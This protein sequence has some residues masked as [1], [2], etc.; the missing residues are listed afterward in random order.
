MI[1]SGT[2]L[3][4]YEV[5]DPLGAG[6]MGEVYKARDTRLDRNV[7]IKVLPPHLASNPDFKLRFE[8]EAKVVSGLNHPN[9]CTLHDIG[10]DS[11]V[12]YLVM[13]LC[14]GETLADRLTR[15]ALPVDQVLRYGAQIAEALERAHRSGIVHRDLKPGNIMLT[16][17]GAKLLD[18]GLAK[19]SP[20]LLT[21]ADGETVQK[22]LTAEGAIVG[23]FQYMAPEQ[24][25][26]RETD[27]RSDIFSFGAILYEMATGKRA[28]DGKTKAS[29]I[30]S[31]L[32][33]QPEPITKLQP[34]APPALERVI[35]HALE[36]D[37]DERWQTAH[38]LLLELRWI[39]EAGSQ[40]GVAA[41]VVMRRKRREMLAWVLAAIALA[42][43]VAAAAMLSAKMRQPAITHWVTVTPPEGVTARFEASNGGSLTL[44]PDGRLLTFAAS[45]EGGVSLLWLRPIDSPDA[46]PI[47]GTEDAIYPFWSPDSRFIAFF[48]EG[49]LK[50]VDVRGGPPLTLCDVQLN[51]RSGSWNREG[52]ILF[53]PNSLSPIHRV[54][55]AGG[56]PVPVT[57][58]DA[59]NG[60]TTHRWAT[61]LPDGK[62]FLY[63][64]GTHADG[65]RSEKN[66]IYAGSLD[67]TTKKLIVYARSNVV[68]TNGHLLYLRDGVLLAHAFDEKK[69]E[70]KGD[71]QSVASSVQYALAWFHGS[72][73]AVDDGTLV[74][75]AGETDP[76]LTLTWNDRAGKELQPAG[77]PERVFDL[78]LSPDGTRMAAA[79]EDAALGTG[80]LWLYDLEGDVRSRFTFD[81]SNEDG[82]VWSPDGTQLVF[83]Q[84]IVGK[85]RSDLFIKPAGGRGEQKLLH[86]SPDNKRA[87]DWSRDGRFIAFDAYSGG[88]KPDVWIV[89]MTDRKASPFLDSEFEESSLR[90]SPDGRWAVYI[91]DESGRS[92]AYVTPFPERGG[93]WQISNNGAEGVVW[94]A[95]GNEIF[96]LAA[97]GIF[98]VDVTAAGSS[99][100]AEPPRLLFRDTAVVGG[101]VSRD[102]QRFLLARTT[103]KQTG[104]GITLVTNWMNTL[105]R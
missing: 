25:E 68:Y 27:A 10:N 3:G 63:L 43:A 11:G 70:V 21:S 41:P 89:S 55:A 53:S 6:G 81:R 39:A 1:E 24:L 23:T 18:F 99:F 65:P 59:A 2:R 52:V 45:G 102:G 16:K 50:K 88:K 71:P 8:R 33:R 32:D 22:P 12:D 94:S 5:L 42:A 91:S 9:I 28:F 76:R 20:V 103:A 82:P 56:K 83:A 34:L 97:A 72:F 101:D 60:E 19:P 98:A 51:P 37:P 75:L 36:K 92:E 96:Y 31:I 64:A 78:R 86:S 35:R 4:P 67:G 66:A 87:T 48:A 46:K 54:P 84:D 14:D 69:L 49:K 40:A 38:D 77:E 80:D 17:G 100:E 58:L 95:Q 73:A 7:A 30:A 104:G 61:F 90:F 15:G 62:R 105:K 93:K 47:P 44:S 29:L 79:I 26:G 85:G 74:F 57:Q 13:E